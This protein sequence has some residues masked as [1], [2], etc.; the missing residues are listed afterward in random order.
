MTNTIL[1]KKCLQKQQLTVKELADLL[2]VSRSTL[3][4]KINN[5]SEFRSM[6]ITKIQKLLKLSYK[7]RDII[8]FDNN[9]D[10]KS[11]KEKRYDL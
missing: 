7:E 6:E 4:R 11:T 8:F 2:N 1:L 3:S 9:V 10:Y 5:K